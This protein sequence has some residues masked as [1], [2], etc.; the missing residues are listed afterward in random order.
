[1]SE[2]PA[3]RAAHDRGLRAEGFVAE[4]LQRRGVEILDRNWR[5]G[6][7]ELDLVV[8]HEARLRF[9]EVKAR[10]DDLVDPLE[11]IDRGKR[12]KLV[13]AAEAWMIAH[14][15]PAEEVAFLVAV[16]D[17]AVTPWSV[18]YLDDAFDG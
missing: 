10:R 16:V 18:R 14:G 2:D 17:L 7:G 9:V 6:G 12:R 11:A 15:L 8:R 1:M 4:D 5:G 13:A 3:R